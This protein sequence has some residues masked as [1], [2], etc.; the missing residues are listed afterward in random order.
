LKY[1]ILLYY[2]TKFDAKQVTDGQE[3]RGMAKKQANS[4]T[5]ALVEK[6]KSQEAKRIQATT[7]KSEFV[8]DTLNTTSDG[9]IVGDLYGYITD[10]NESILKMYGTTDKTEFIGKNVFSFAVKND[11]Q[12][13]VN[14]SLNM[15]M[16]DQGQKSEYRA[17][18]KN[19]E[20]I[21]VEVTTAFMRDENAEKIGFV[22]TITI[23]PF[24][25]EKK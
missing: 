25:S 18:R 6:F 15:I 23:L 1:T 10:V 22:N 14:N 13:A 24:T 8:H 19:G 17:I 21:Q 9:V 20:E 3:S 4:T 5:D 12:R 11:K 2:K 16:A 7:M